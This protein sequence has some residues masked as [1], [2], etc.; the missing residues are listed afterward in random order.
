MNAKTA[1]FAAAIAI[2]SLIATPVS[3]QVTSAS[4]KGSTTTPTPTA[5]ATATPTPTPTP[6]VIPT[7]AP[8]PTPTV[9][10]TTPP[11]IAES[12][13][14]DQDEENW[15]FAAPPSTSEGV[16]SSFDE[17]LGAVGITTEQSAN[18]F[19]WFKSPDIPAVPQALTDVPQSV[20]Y[21]ALWSFAS[22]EPQGAVL[23]PS[24]NPTLRMRSTNINLTR[25]DEL[26]INSEE[27][28]TLTPGNASKT[29]I[30]LFEQRTDTPGF[31]LFFDHFNFFDQKQAGVTYLLDEVIL[32]VI[33]PA[34]LPA[35][36]NEILYDFTSDE[37]TSPTF[38]Q[39]NAEMFFSTPEDF[40]T[41]GG[42]AIRGVNPAPEVA[43]AQNIL[44]TTT[45][46]FGFWGTEEVDA[47][48][49]QAGEIYRLE[50][51]VGSDAATSLTVPTFR[52][53]VNDESLQFAAV[54][55]IES[56]E[57][58]VIPVAGEDQTYVQW[59]TIPSEID[60]ERLL[61]S[62]DYISAQGSD[63]DPG[64]ALILRSLNVQILPPP[65]IEVEP[66]PTPEPTPTATATPTPTP[67]LPAEL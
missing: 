30:Q 55:Q 53:R 49:V 45:T 25:S 65:A 44:P 32:E 20:G 10:P 59:F 48:T 36:A 27:P 42:L 8:S 39:G 22:M 28:A 15:E 66:E 40:F 63:N 33:D 56:E 52:L 35:P 43:P 1:L 38:A 41:S 29:F 9:V 7:T 21:T 31:N 51:T 2:G 57:G 5:T 64:V 14:F 37:P 13:F 3:A 54:T 60:G 34:G 18:A 16:V 61:L 11:I 47:L 6:T 19:G 46:V 12:F 62:F 23:D 24:D 17:M 26:Q 58:G 50:W 4:D 67:T